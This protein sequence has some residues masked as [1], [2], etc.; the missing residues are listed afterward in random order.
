MAHIPRCAEPSWGGCWAPLQWGRQREGRF[1]PAP[2]PGPVLTHIRTSTANPG[3]AGGK[4]LPSPGQPV[5]FRHPFPVSCFS[6]GLLLLSQIQTPRSTCLPLQPPAAQEPLPA[7]CACSTEAEAI[8]PANRGVPSALHSNTSVQ[9]HFLAKAN[10][11]Y[12]TVTRCQLSSCYALF[13]CAGLGSHLGKLHCPK[14]CHKYLHPTADVSPC[15]RPARDSTE[16]PALLWTDFSLL[17]TARF[18]DRRA[19]SGNPRKPC[20]C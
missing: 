11:R 15:I 19:C 3:I 20:K 7:A 16:T 18:G 2:L 1:L 10:K 13:G 9:T 14:R 8:P 4:L 6:Q 5:S 17:P 12:V